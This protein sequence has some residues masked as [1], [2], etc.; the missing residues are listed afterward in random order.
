M[1]AALAHPLTPAVSILEEAGRD[2]A[3]RFAL[4]R[5]AAD[6]A[7]DAGEEG[8]ARGLA[9]LAANERAP[10]HWANTPA[11]QGSWM[12]YAYGSREGVSLDPNYWWGS[13]G[14]HLPLPLW[15]RISREEYAF[16]SSGCKVIS[17]FAQ[18]V[19]AA[20]RAASE[21]NAR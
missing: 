5:L 13:H 11:Q 7:L 2:A 14:H 12:W 18:A 17:G 20:A 10:M 4:Y 21:E 15:K 16:K 9:W 8:A 1:T 3:S 6:A 19:L